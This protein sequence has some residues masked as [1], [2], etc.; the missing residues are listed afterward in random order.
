MSML[1][2]VRDEREMPPSVSQKVF[3]PVESRQRRDSEVFELGSRA[4]FVSN[5]STEVVL[6]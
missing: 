3:T 2:V 1:S 5:Q 6:F 4:F